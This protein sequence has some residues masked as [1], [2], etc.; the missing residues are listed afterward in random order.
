MRTIA[1]FDVFDTVLVRMTGT[2]R[3]VFEA[4]GRQL[5]SEGVTGC[6]PTAYAAA[7]E[8]AVEVLTVDKARHPT[9]AVI[10]RETAA[11][12]GL[13][14]DAADRLAEAEAQVEAEGL[15][16]VPGMVERL[17]AE[18]VGTGHGVVF[19]SDTCLSSRWL[20]D[21]LGERGLFRPG[22][23]VYVSCEA[24]ASKQH[25]GLFAA[26]AAD[27]GVPPATMSHH[28]DDRW[29]DVAHARLAGWR[30][31]WLPQG[32][33]TAREQALLHRSDETDGATARLAAAARYARLAAGHRGLVDEAADVVGI[34]GSVA[35]PVLVGFGLWVLG[36]ARQRGLDRLYFMSRDGELL[37]Q[38]VS[39]L[40]DAAGMAIDCRYLY[41][42]RR[43]WQ[44]SAR[45]G[46][47]ADDS[48]RPWV[49]DQETAANKTPRQLLALIDLRPE[50]LAGS[51][52]SGLSA[53]GRA[54]RPCGA[55]LAGEIVRAV[56]Q[57]P[58]AGIARER[59]RSG[60]ERLLRYLDQEGVTDP[61]ARVALVD[62]GWSG[63][64]ARVFEDVLAGT[65]R[66]LPVAH[67]YVGL[68]RAAPEAM[69]P[70][71][72]ERSE[73][74]MIDG[75]RG[76]VPDGDA[77]DFVRLIETL[78]MG[79]EGTTV[80]FA[81]EGA[82]VVPVL[83]HE[84]NPETDRWRFEEYR[85]GVLDAVDA[86]ARTD[87]GPAADL[88]VDLRSATWAPLLGLWRRPSPAEAR[89]WGRQPFGDDFGNDHAVPLASPMTVRRVLAR[90]GVRAGEWREP[91]YW[92]PGSLVLTPSPLRPV[93]ATVDRGER[94]VPR[95]RR[96]PRRLR[97]E[98]VLRHGRR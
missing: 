84:R 6:S 44:L 15:V 46:A 95:L 80:G 88:A 17:E 75:G 66:P 79:A 36:Q 2:P 77:E 29:S 96:L 38:V 70:E 87:P 22:D 23:A 55:G 19:V 41:G 60:R 14:R 62:V 73:G 83:A 81:D 7:R 33:F 52:V 3:S 98:W 30:A 25:G 64:A 16:A 20:R 61:S 63:K 34:A 65:D 86:Y 45:G 47:R 24:G 12:L 31:T 58:L 51:A 56:A 11:R 8:A 39:R 1:S 37:Q 71:L 92:L 74:W 21:V 40:A 69:G 26:V 91:T 42:S 97:A 9:L 82:R 5:T 49:P 57:E 28:G 53:A 67:L 93:L 78:C 18:R 76:R 13:P 54:D 4:V 68:T 32:A 94:A 35:A 72:F 50:D 89:A 10:A 27:L 90:L 59:A 48:R 85:T 43:S